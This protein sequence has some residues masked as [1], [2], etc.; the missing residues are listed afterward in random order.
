MSG[1]VAESPPVPFQTSVRILQ[2]PKGM[3]KVHPGRAEV[4]VRGDHLSGGLEALPAD[5]GDSGGPQAVCSQT[6]S[7]KGEE[8][9]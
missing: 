8:R 6:Q 5:F 7:N 2:C 3:K 1:A 9:V 4:S